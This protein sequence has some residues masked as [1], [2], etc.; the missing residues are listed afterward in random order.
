VTSPKRLNLARKWKV[1]K[2][3]S[4]GTVVA[5]DGGL[6]VVAGPRSVWEIDVD[7]GQPAAKHELPL[8][9]KAEVTS[10][11]TFP[12]GDGKPIY[13]VF[14]PLQPG[15][16]VLDADWKVMFSY[17]TGDE[18]PPVRDVQLS[19]LDENG[20]PELLVA[21]DGNIGL[22]C[23]SL[24]GERQW[25]NRAYVPLVSVALSHKWKEI[26]RFAY[27]T[28][29]GGICPITKEGIDSEPKVVSPWVVAHLFTSSFSDAQ[30]AA[31]AAI[32]IDAKGAP[33][34]VGLSTLLEEQW[35]YPLPGGSFQRPVDFV[36]S[37]KLRR[38]SQG[39]W[40]AA[41]ADG[42]IH[43]VS[44]D[45]NFDDTFNTGSEIR[46]VAVLEREGKPLLVVSTPND[47][48]AWEV[49]P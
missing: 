31:Y 14:S 34:V 29:R 28:G 45:G 48:L 47:V 21:F 22:H 49:G 12:G 27:V 15:V 38:E 46:G 20:E 44:E 35:S 10:L 11:R 37:G 33:S 16:H 26:G 36:A 39:E 43:I 7:R 1:D 32:A 8:P 24:A 19:D 23:V 42:S 6:L 13:A 17:P 41:W 25:S 3:T 18:A 4:G 9:E 40:I 5:A 2:L 30:Q